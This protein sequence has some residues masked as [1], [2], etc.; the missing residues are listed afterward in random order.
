MSNRDVAL[1]RAAVDRIRSIS[2]DDTT[3][4][5]RDAV[6]MILDI[7]NENISDSGG[8]WDQVY[9]AIKDA[10]FKGE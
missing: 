2:G 5:D 3:E 6:N 1:L 7:L 10:Y 9:E 4:E 8:V